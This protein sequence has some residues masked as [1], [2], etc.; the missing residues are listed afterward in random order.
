MSRTLE[1]IMDRLQ[2]MADPANVAGMARYGINPR[3]TLGVSVAELRKIAGEIGK[4]HVR[5]GELWRTGI[6]EAR[7]LAALVDVA[8]E[9]S[10]DQ[11]ETW[12]AD[13]DSWDVCD[14]CCNNLFRRTRWARDKAREWAGREEEFVKRAG[15]VLMATLAVH[16][17]EEGDSLFVEFLALIERE[18]GDERNFVKKS[19]NWALRQIGK[20]NQGL[21]AAAVDTAGRIRD[22]PSKAARWIAADALRELENEKTLRRVKE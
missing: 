13:V 8:A 18:A 12:V 2:S 5:A 7:I 21:N 14:L 9:V 20:R 15:F 1:E 16:E 10:E 4:D 11:M 6:H 3:G 17:K 22:F 19:V